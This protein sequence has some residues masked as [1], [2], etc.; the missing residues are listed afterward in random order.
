MALR[1]EVSGIAVDVRLFHEAGSQLVHKYR[2]YKDPLPHPALRG[3]GGGNSQVTFVVWTGQWP[4]PSS[5]NYR[6]LSRRQVLPRGKYQS[7]GRLFSKCRHFGSYDR[8]TT[9]VLC[10]GYSD[11]DG[12]HTTS[13]G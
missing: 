4:L 3:G 7:T 13:V 9:G 10:T 2:V 11:V 12:R 5:H 1:P 6:Y 8:T